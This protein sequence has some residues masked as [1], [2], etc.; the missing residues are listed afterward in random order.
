MSTLDL[1]VI[2]GYFLI[3]FAIGFYFARPREDEQ[4]LLPRRS[5]RRLDCRRRVALRHEHLERTLHRAGRLGRGQRA[6]GRTLRVAGQRSC[7][8]SLGWLFVPFYLR[9]AVSRCRSSSSGATG[10]RAAGI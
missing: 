5:Q 1:V 10:R 7:A 6:R 8:W 4:G 3:V 2:A 9:S